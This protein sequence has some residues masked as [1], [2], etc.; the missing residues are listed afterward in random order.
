VTP[1]P[2]NPTLP[3]PTAETA[4]GTPVASAAEL[5]AHA[6]KI[7]AD[8]AEHYGLL[9]EQM[10]THNNPEVAKLF[11]KLEWVEGLHAGKILERAADTTLPTLRPWESIW[12]GDRSPEAVDLGEAHY[13][14]TPWQALQMALKAE[15]S[16]FAFYDRLAQAATDP[17]IKQLATEFA[18]EEREHVE[19]V[20]KELEKYPPP[21]KGWSEDPDPAGTPD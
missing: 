19:L 17:E 9:A 12:P 18:A 5:L 10:E 6:H 7:E 3:E 14:M 13:L 15:R 8:A 16:A 20:H 21:E 1:D 2:K 4:T 11:R